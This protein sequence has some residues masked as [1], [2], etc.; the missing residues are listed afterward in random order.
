MAKLPCA[1]AG[2]L[3]KPAMWFQSIPTAIS[4]LSQFATH[5]ASTVKTAAPAAAAPA[6]ATAGWI[7]WPLS[8]LGFLDRQPA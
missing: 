4:M 3:A 7:R 1:A 8:T 2:P 5:V 6:P